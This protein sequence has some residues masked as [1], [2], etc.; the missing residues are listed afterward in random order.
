LS[1]RETDRV[2][3]IV[4]ELDLVRIESPSA[5]RALLPEIRVLTALESMACICPVE[6]TTG[7]GVERFEIENFA[8]GTRFR[9]LTLEYLSRAPRRYGCFDP[10]DPEATQRNV[11]LDLEDLVPRE[12]LEKSVGFAHVL[13][14]LRLDGHRVVR[15][16]ICDETSL[17]AWF[18]GFQTGP[19]TDNQRRLIG[20]LLPALRRRLSLERRLD[21]APLMAAAL[22]ATLEHIA[23]PAFVVNGS[24]RV[25]EANAA[26]KALLATSGSE[27]SQSLRAALAKQPGSLRFDVTP[28]R[29]QGLP[30][31]SL[32]V[33][34]S[35]T[36]DTRVA[37]SIARA[38]TRLKLT[39]RQR[40]VLVLLMR[41]HSNISIASALQIR[42]RAVE[43]HV[44]ALLDRAAVDSR[45]A[46]I[47]QVFLKT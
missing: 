24:G 1:K 47:A 6:R 7:W 27:V 26:G 10:V 14:P 21:A 16:L 3:E 4:A 37:V 25:F 20:L 31:H 32:A 33:L 42:E 28:F 12:D 40:D 29:E 44:S 46:L 19:I 39:P 30:E 5:I 13:R 8:N 45:A 2:G 11:V 36:T 35:R 22:A 41:G 34:G 38:V 15:A 18:G 23:S 9:Q 17:L 43:Q